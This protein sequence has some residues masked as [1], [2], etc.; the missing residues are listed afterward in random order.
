MGKTEFGASLGCQM[1]SG[2]G[3]GVCSFDTKFRSKFHV[4]SSRRA[5]AE[6]ETVDQMY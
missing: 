2:V 5:T 6:S 3:D 1:G 4:G